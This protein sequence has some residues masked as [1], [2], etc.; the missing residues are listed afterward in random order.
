MAGNPKAQVPLCHSSLPPRC[1]DDQMHA[2]S[3]IWEAARACS[4][5]FL[6]STEVTS[7]AM[8][9]AMTPSSPF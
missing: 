7:L 6:K 1:M 3:P 8:P 2:T 5:S 4:P 9:A